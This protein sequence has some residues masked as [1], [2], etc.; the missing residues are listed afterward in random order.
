[1]RPSAPRWMQ[2]TTKRKRDQKVHTESKKA[3]EAALEKT[4]GNIGDICAKAAE[5]HEQAVRAYEKRVSGMARAANKALDQWKA[6]VEK[7]SQETNQLIKQAKGSQRASKQDIEAYKAA[8][9][10]ILA[11]QEE[12]Q[13]VI[14]DRSVRDVHAVMTE[15][16][17]LDGVL[18]ELSRVSRALEEQLNK[19]GAM[20]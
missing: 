1:M 7:L 9:V 2:E 18:K 10:R 4:I 3:K 16:L 14:A 11:D 6:D 8:A 13:T 12:R 19:V 5:E 17:P 20:P 15:D